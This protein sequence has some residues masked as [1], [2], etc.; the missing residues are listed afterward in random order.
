MAVN[1]TDVAP[2]NE[3]MPITADGQLPDPV[4]LQAI[5]N[6]F[7]QLRIQ[8][9]QLQAVQSQATQAQQQAQAAQQTANTPP[10]SV[11]QGATTANIAV[12]TN[13][14][15]N[16]PQVDLL[17]VVAGNLTLSATVNFAPGGLIS[18]GASSGEGYSTLITATAEMRIVEIVGA[19]ET[20]VYP[21]SGTATVS[22]YGYF[23]VTSFSYVL[24]PNFTADLAAFVAARVSAGAVSYRMDFR[25]TSP[26]TGC[27]LTNVSAYLFAQRA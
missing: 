18:G 9:A 23:S 20:Q 25:V 22:A 14:W 11:T 5:N 13:A 1:P 17:G 16:G 12:V 6:A 26:A 3:H 21:P 8:V 2:L 7:Q 24:A 27:A 15:T 19:T 4:F 10:A